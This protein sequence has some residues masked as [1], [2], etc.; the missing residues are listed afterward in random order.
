MKHSKYHLA[1]QKFLKMQI[2]W[3]YQ[4]YSKCEIRCKEVWQET[5]F[6]KCINRE[7]VRYD[8]GFDWNM[9]RLLRFSSKAR[10][11]LL[12][13]KEPMAKWPAMK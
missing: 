11:V 2:E 13:F 7:N 5:M 1:L 8:A 9:H 10:K 6:F 3:N 4:F 12:D